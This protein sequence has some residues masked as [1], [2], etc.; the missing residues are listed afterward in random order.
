MQKPCN[1]WNGKNIDDKTW[2]VGLFHCDKIPEQNNLRE[3]RFI[4]AHGFSPSGQGGCSSVGHLN[5]D[6]KQR[7]REC[8]C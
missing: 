4:L 1:S 2:C 6:R 5:M 3:E 7:E 8:L